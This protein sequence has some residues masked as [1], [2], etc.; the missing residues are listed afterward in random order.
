MKNFTKSLIN[1]VIDLEYPDH[2]D[3]PLSEY[4]TPILASMA[5]TSLFPTGKGDLFAVVYNEDKD[6]VLNK[7]K[8]LLYYAEIV[9]SV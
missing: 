1:N 9:D 2:S 5:F 6:T 7:V 3:E 4:N 8:N